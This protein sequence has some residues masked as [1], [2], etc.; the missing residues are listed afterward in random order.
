[1]LVFEAW[2]GKISYW[3]RSSRRCGK[4]VV[5]GVWMRWSRERNIWVERLLLPSLALSL[6]HR[7]TYSRC[8][9]VTFLLVPLNLELGHEILYNLDLEVV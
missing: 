4:G 2:R 1:M 3:N 9:L 7:R 8:F 6:P 5:D